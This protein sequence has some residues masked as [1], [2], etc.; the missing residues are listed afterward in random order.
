MIGGELVLASA[1]PARASLLENAGFRVTRVPAAIDEA[2]VKAAFRR[3]GADAAICAVALATA[4]AERVS[5][6][7]SGALVVG[8]DQLLVCGDAW[9]DKPPDLDHARAQ[10]RALRG[11]THELVTA[12]VVFRDGHDLWHHVARP[13]LTMRSFSDTFLD[14]YLAAAGPDVLG[15]VGAYQLEKLGAHLFAR[16]EGDY[17]SILGLPLLP[18]LDFLRAQQ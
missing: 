18:L 6:R 10:L 7:H 13:R 11:R 4:K 9:F 14:E 16:V 15:S 12:V 8:A 1:S 2:E 3:E 17:F 5:R